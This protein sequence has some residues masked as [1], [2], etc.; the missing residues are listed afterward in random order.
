MRKSPLL[1]AI[2]RHAQIASMSRPIQVYNST[3]QLDSD[4]ISAGETNAVHAEIVKAQWISAPSDFSPFDAKSQMETFVPV[5]PN[6]TDT[7]LP[8]SFEEIPFSKKTDPEEKQPAK[9]A[10]STPEATGEDKIWRRLQTIFNRHQEKD[11][12]EKTS[13]LSPQTHGIAEPSADPAA[14]MDEPQNLTKKTKEVDA[15]PQKPTFADKPVQ[16]QIDET[17][18]PTPAE[19]PLT[20]LSLDEETKGA[21][22]QI[23]TEV[24]TQKNINIENVNTFVIE[25]Q[26]SPIPEDSTV[27]DQQTPK[28]DDL[29]PDPSLSEIVPEVF[30]SSQKAVSF[31]AGKEEQPTPQF[32]E[33]KPD[34]MVAEKMNSQP[35][36]V[37]PSQSRHPAFPDEEKPKVHS[38]PL[39]EAWPVQGNIFAKEIKKEEAQTALAAPDQPQT[40]VPDTQPLQKASQAVPSSE[41]TE[42]HQIRNRLEHISTFPSE[43]SIESIP[44]RRPRP[45][46][47]VEQKTASREQVQ[48]QADDCAEMAQLSLEKEDTQK[49]D[50][51]LEN[52]DNQPSPPFEDRSIPS[53]AEEQPGHRPVNT[54]IGELPSDLWKLIGQTPPSP[55]ERDASVGPAGQRLQIQQAPPSHP[56]VMRSIDDHAVDS[57]EIP[58]VQRQT[59]P[60]DSASNEKIPSSKGE[61]QKSG[62]PEVNIQELAQKVYREIKSKLAIEWE[63]TRY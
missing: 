27:V 30:S 42:I 45:N 61:D 51:F 55:A 9:L 4:P 33:N 12:Q 20:T 35:E 58:P 29:E 24:Q 34:E 18:P 31:S 40:E 23:P 14:A 37:E 50:A 39:Q 43:S 49:Q 32:V 44:P 13:D 46:S 57:P 28:N 2:K 1:N 59:E 63:R 19:Q 56:Q 21:V 41:D 38:V 36:L 53:S 7:G 47:F 15:K 48:R 54:E 8:K 52:V 25:T 22:G 5:A 17:K 10:S 60:D 16:R 3:F 11:R 62:Q 6:I 26:T